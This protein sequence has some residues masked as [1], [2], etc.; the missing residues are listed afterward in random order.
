MNK[1][2][3][4]I[5]ICLVMVSCQKE[6]FDPPNNNNFSPT[7]NSTSSIESSSSSSLS[8]KC[9]GCSEWQKCQK[10]FSDDL[11]SLSYKYECRSIFRHLR[12]GRYSSIEI[13]ADSSDNIISNNRYLYFPF[14]S[15]GNHATLDIGIK[16][17]EIDIYFNTDFDY[18]Y[19]FNFNVSNCIIYNPITETNMI[20]E[21][22]GLFTKNVS[23]P[24]YSV[25]I[26]LKSISQNG[27]F[28]YMIKGTSGN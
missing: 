16:N 2:I 5:I 6:I 28:S 4:S 25:E 18:P 15:N 22:T 12:Q 20:F 21:G 1:V 8:S 3:S 10:K 27:N 26:N 13:F 11:F 14:M 19:Y 17:T 9:T 23:S 24:Y 7:S